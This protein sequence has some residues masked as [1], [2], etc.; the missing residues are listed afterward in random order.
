[1]SHRIINATKCSPYVELDPNGK[2][3]LRGRSILEDTPAFYKPIMEWVNNATCK[4]LTVEIQLEYMN[5]SS[6]KSLFN[7]LKAI[8]D[9]PMVGNVYVKWYYEEDDEDMFEIGQD[10]ESSV[11]LPFDYYTFAV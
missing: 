9:N 11:F 6:T 10:F 7:V 8:K 1:M 4:E 3:I 5:T 2:I